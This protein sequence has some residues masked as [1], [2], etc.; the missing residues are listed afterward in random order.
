MD[1]NKLEFSFEKYGFEWYERLMK[2]RGYSLVSGQGSMWSKLIGEM[3]DESSFWIFATI[4]KDNKTVQ[5][6]SNPLKMLISLQS[7]ELQVDHPHF[8]DFEKKL[9]DYID[10]CLQFDW[11]NEAIKRRQEDRDSKRSNQT[12]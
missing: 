11:V 3:S 6:S 4:D 10:Q 9:I 8:E 5:L 7:S 2:S 12:R 1:I